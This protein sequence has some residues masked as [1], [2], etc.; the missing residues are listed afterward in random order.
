LYALPEIVRAFKSISA[1][2]I[3]FNNHTPGVPFW[4]RGYYDHIIRDETELNAVR[5]YI[6]NN[7]LQWSLDHENCHSTD[8][9]F[10]QSITG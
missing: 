4:Q 1:K 9:E 10:L 6:I 3:N 7:P 2:I 5:D 8:L